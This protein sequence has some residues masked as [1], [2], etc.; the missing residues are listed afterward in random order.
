MTVLELTDV[1]N[2]TMPSYQ[3]QL[4]T[5]GDV[6]TLPSLTSHDDVLIVDT[7]RDLTHRRLNH[8]LTI[9]NMSG[10]ECVPCTIGKSRK[11]TSRHD[12][13]GWLSAPPGER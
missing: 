3:V 2:T 10:K 5:S 7:G 4:D 11:R 6:L 12:F 9:L 8:E 13:S 1:V